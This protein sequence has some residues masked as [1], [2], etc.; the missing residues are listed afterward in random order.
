MKYVVVADDNPLLVSVLAEI[1]NGSG[2]IVRMAV[3]GFAS[4]DS[5]SS[6]LMSGCECRGDRAVLL[7]WCASTFRRPHCA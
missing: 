6:K 2:Y 5:D 1:F 3:D 4:G 7:W